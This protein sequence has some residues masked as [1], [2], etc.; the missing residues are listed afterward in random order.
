MKITTNQIL[1]TMHIYSLDSI[2]WFVTFFI[3]MSK[4]YFGKITN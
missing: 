2:H 4:N 3:N 1:A